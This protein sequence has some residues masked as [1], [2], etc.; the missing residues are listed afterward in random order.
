[1]SE[2]APSRPPSSAPTIVPSRH[3]ADAR[4]AATQD[5]HGGRIVATVSE[6]VGEFRNTSTDGVGAV[7]L[8]VPGIVDEERGIGVRSENLGWRNVPFRDLVAERTRLPVAFGHDV[9]RAGGL[10]EYRLGAARNARTALFLPIGTGIAAALIVDGRIHAGGGYAGEIGHVDVGHGEP[11]ACGSVGCLEAIASAAAIA[12]R[13]TRAAGTPVPGALEVADR[14]R[15]SDPVARRVWDEAVETVA[16]ALSWAASVLAP[17]IV[18]V[19][20]GLAESGDLLLGPL[21]EALKRR[22]TFQRVPRLVPA[23]LGDDAGWLGA[24]L[25]A[26][27]LLGLSE[28]CDVASGRRDRH[29]HPESRARSHI[30]D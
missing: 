17:E 13:Y 1:M 30:Q 10:A 5:T 22:L 7:G 14:L 18:V 25:L 6:I 23:A 29:R 9:V 27:D 8:V 21:R 11:C 19:G 15:A 12:R 16:L 2:A 24:A 20:G 4:R 26:R 28:S 3:S